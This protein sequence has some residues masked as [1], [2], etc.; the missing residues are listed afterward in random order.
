VR[1]VAIN[2]S[3]TA[4]RVLGFT[5][6]PKGARDGTLDLALPAG[7]ALLLHTS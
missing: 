3:P 1:I 5:G 2:T 4:S 6:L 7:S